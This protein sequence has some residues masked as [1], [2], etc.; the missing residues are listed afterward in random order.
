MK[1]RGR[2]AVDYRG[3]IRRWAEQASVPRWTEQ[4]WRALMGRA[5]RQAPD[6]VRPRRAP[7]W[8]P[9][10]AG[11]AM[12]AALVTGA[13]FLSSG[14]AAIP[15]PPPIGTVPDSRAGEMLP[16]D[17]V[18][19]VNPQPPRPTL[20]PDESYPFRQHPPA[21]PPAWLFLRPGSGPTVFQFVRPPAPPPLSR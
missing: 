10:L 4:E 7:L 11:A 16:A 17:P 5:V 6:A 12:L 18:R 13:W 14:G 3:Q 8:Q 21:N 20:A 15:T 2:D 9:A 1:R 19:L